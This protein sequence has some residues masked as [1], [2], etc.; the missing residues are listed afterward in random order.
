MV[1]FKIT[2]LAKL[3]QSWMIRRKSLPKFH[4]D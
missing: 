2:D 3:G 4:T 1:V